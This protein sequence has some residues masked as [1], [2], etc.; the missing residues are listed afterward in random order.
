MTTIP[1]SC[2]PGMKSSK[3]IRPLCTVW[4]YVL[5]YAALVQHSDAEQNKNCKYTRV[6]FV[7]RFI[8]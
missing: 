8:L 4:V 2:G 1:T 5:V 3:W 6:E 7:V